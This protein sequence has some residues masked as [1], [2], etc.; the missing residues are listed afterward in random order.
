MKSAKSRTLAVAA[1]LAFLFMQP[2]GSMFMYVVDER[3]IAVVLQFGEP[4]EARSEPG[5]YFKLPLM[6]EV[7]ILP[8]TL[9]FWNG[10]SRTDTLVD[11]P[12]A[13]GKKVEA[14][15]WA[16]WR[17]TDPIRFVQTLRT[18]EAAQGR[19]VDFV[20]SG[21]RDTITR[22]PLHELV[23]N[24]DRELTHSFAGGVP[25]V[26]TGVESVGEATLPLK[27]GREKIVRQM[28]ADIATALAGED[29]SGATRGIELVDV[30]VS[31]IEFVAEVR[32]AA[33][34]KQIAAMTAIA[35]KAIAEGDQLKQEIINR[36]Q[37]EIQQLQGEGAEKA[38]TLKGEADAEVIRS[39]AAAIE[40]SGDFFRFVRTLETYKA[41]LGGKTHLILSTDSDLFRMLKEAP[42]VQPPAP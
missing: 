27:L 16:V 20:R 10:S 24:T 9:R 33:F 13:D 4:V 26:L 36:T 32:Q 5:W 7:R 12:T 42:A 38:S 15:L 22:Y 37:A 17:I 6:Q 29:A 30:G 35:N 25:G 23:R 2:L 14:N 39:Y 3:Q 1:L 41:A 8:K 28:K 34:E 40:Q 19:V 21:A 18:E 31:R 11:V